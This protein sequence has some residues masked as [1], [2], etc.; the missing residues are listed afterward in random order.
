VSQFFI[1]RKP[2]PEPLISEQPIAPVEIASQP[3]AEVEAPT[4]VREPLKDK[5][6]WDVFGDFSLGERTPFVGSALEYKE[7]GTLVNAARRVQRGEGTAKDENMLNAFLREQER[8]R[9][10]TA[11]VADVA[12]DIPRFGIEIVASGGAIAGGKLVGKK[13]AQVLVSDIVRKKVAAGA[14]KVTAN[15]YL[16]SKLVKGV[17]TVAAR[18]AVIDALGGVAG[19]VLGM[20]QRGGM[21][22]AAAARKALGRARWQKDEFGRF[23]LLMD[24]VVPTTLE[25]MPQGVIDSMIEVGTELVGGKLVKGAGSAVARAAQKAGIQHVPLSSQVKAL[26][27][28]IADAWVNKVPGGAMVSRALTMTP[29]SKRTIQQLMAIGERGGYNG[30]VGE[31][32]EERLG[33]ALN[34]GAGWL[35]GYEEDFDGLE[36]LFPG[37]ADLSVEIAAFA[38]PVGAMRGAM[39][40]KQKAIGSYYGSAVGS[41]A[42][43]QE[44]QR[45]N[46]GRPFEGDSALTKK[47]VNRARFTTSPQASLGIDDIRDKDPSYTIGSGAL[48]PEERLEQERDRRIVGGRAYASKGQVDIGFG[49]RGTTIDIRNKQSAPVGFDSIMEAGIELANVPL[50]DRMTAEGTRATIGVGR[51]GS[52]GVMKENAK[53][54]QFYREGV[55]DASLHARIARAKDVGE[56][57]VRSMQLVLLR[58]YGNRKD[59]THGRAGL[60]LNIKDFETGGELGMD[61]GQ[62]IELLALGSKLDPVG[63]GSGARQAHRGMLEFFRMYMTADG[64]I[65]EYMPRT[66]EW[67][68][69]V[70]SVNEPD[71]KSSMDA[72]RAKVNDFRYQGAWNRLQ[73]QHWDKFSNAEKLRKIS[74][75]VSTADGRRAVVTKFYGK[76]FSRA[77]YLRDFNDARRRFYKEVLGKDPDKN[78]DLIDLFEAQAKIESAITQQFIEDYPIN[79]LRERVSGHSLID[80]ARMVEDA[81]P[82]FRHYLMLKRALAI[83]EDKPAE[84]EVDA[85]TGVTKLK[86]FGG[87]GRS[88]KTKEVS[89]PRLGGLGHNDVKTLLGQMDSRWENFDIAAKALY[90]WWDN[91]LDFA[92]ESSNMMAATVDWMRQRDPGNF[93]P[94]E[95]IFDDWVSKEAQQTTLTLES[96][97]G[98][99]TAP[100]EG[101]M[102]PVADVFDA[103]VKKAEEIIATG[104]EFR[105]QEE[106]LK[107]ADEPWQ[108]PFMR[109]LRPDEVPDHTAKVGAILQKIQA[110]TKARMEGQDYDFMRGALQDGRTKSGG[111][112]VQ[113]ISEILKSEEENAQSILDGMVS[114]MGINRNPTDRAQNLLTRMNAE[115]LVE[116]IEI[117]DPGVMAF[118]MAGM[119]QPELGALGTFMTLSKKVFTLGTTG[120]R[121]IFIAK[122]LIRD[123]LTGIIN[124]QSDVPVWTPTATFMQLIRGGGVHQA[125]FLG[126]WWSELTAEFSYAAKEAKARRTGE[127]LQ[128][129]EARDLADRLGGLSATQ[130]RNETIYKRDLLKRLVGKDKG[131]FVRAYDWYMNVLSASENVTRVTEAKL[132][133]ERLKREGRLLNLSKI[134]EREAI[135]L[136]LAMKRVS[137]NFSVAGEVSGYLNMFIPFFNAAIQGPRDTLRAIVQA[138]DEDRHAKMMRLLVGITAPSIALWF[139]TRD[140]DWWIELTDEERASNWYLPGPGGTQVLA[141]PMP[142]EIGTI[143]AAMP[144]SI[145]D[146]WYREDPETLDSFFGDT[147]Q[148]TDAV[149]NQLFTLAPSVTPPLVRATLD[150]ARNKKSFFNIPIVNQSL[151]N[152]APEAQYDEFTT[153]LAKFLGRLPVAAGF[154]SGWSP[155]KI[156]YIIGALGGGLSLDVAK[157]LTGQEAQGL[158]G[159][160]A[161]PVV[162]GFFKEPLAHPKTIQQVFDAYHARQVRFDTKLVDEDEN[163]RATR[164]AMRDAMRAITAIGV[165]MR[166]VS[167]RDER[168]ALQEERLRI[169]REAMQMHHAGKVDPEQRARAVEARKKYE[170]AKKDIRE[171]ERQQRRE[172]LGE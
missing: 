103:L 33:G 161:V 79:Y 58:R 165:I 99:V 162:G 100:L 132:V 136:I 138:S 96:L 45:V 62:L 29:E 150:V 104:L 1:P 54:S 141:V 32:L 140:E 160:F 2:D 125:T 154:E 90:E 169:A 93:M 102:E 95:R 66:T 143:F 137:T 84:W 124:T 20:E 111:E 78:E 109:V 30:I 94:L 3:V 139:M 19:G 56:L 28:K 149:V 108:Q 40:V 80:V 53:T 57:A 74:R 151:Q 126:A 101:S 114:F 118:Y 152:L 71:I 6:V 159:I 82:E 27:L 155:K 55:N 7:L 115:G 36:Q 87:T 51:A 129:S 37:F 92:A 153:G 145:L 98:S 34:I 25:M 67:F 12:L 163:E 75:W 63:G 81:F 168:A 72:F 85:E 110:Y 73:L 49:L 26:Q 64:A 61:D 23:E 119:K 164:T 22:H 127:P 112:L 42:L 157:T 144:V 134:D 15:R 77:G 47:M 60:Q 91:I 50:D 116:Y 171:R 76:Y 9:T 106:L 83:W 113:K 167:D 38:I 21:I 135:E 97:G 88:R 24:S 120:A 142:F 43:N 68:E 128:K 158:G 122:N 131:R 35:P 8:G 39:A 31:V 117:T 65:R 5:T 52:V 16:K 166:D 105:F 107:H 11:A 69:K 172:N 41:A 133:A 44:Q 48:T 13:A 46:A 86:A 14:A 147:L 170:P 17:G 10:W 18:V 89:E 59:E 123:F 156:D 70:F 130:I 121:P 4:P 146:A 148:A